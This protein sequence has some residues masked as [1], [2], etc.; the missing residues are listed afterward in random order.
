MDTVLNIDKLKNELSRLRAK[1]VRQTQA[2]ES[3]EQLILSIE[4][5]I[6]DME[7]KK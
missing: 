1:K 3:N 5:M 6:T 2:L 7:K 4:K